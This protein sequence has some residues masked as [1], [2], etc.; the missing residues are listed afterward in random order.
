MPDINQHN[1][2][3]DA[4]EALIDA[5]SLKYVVNLLAEICSAK[6][7]HVNTNWQDK[8]LAGLWDTNAAVLLNAADKL[9]GQ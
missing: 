3:L 8:G 5:N 2:N 6:S 4:I 1:T 7:D 9:Q